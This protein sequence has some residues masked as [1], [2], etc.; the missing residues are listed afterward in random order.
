MYFKSRAH[1]GLLLANLLYDSYRYENCAVLAVNDGGVSVGEQIATQ[2]HCPLM[3]LL[4]E[5]IEV[6]GESVSFGSVSQTGN[7]TY[8]S[9][10]SSGEIDG[11][12]SEFHG[13]LAEQKREKF[14]KINRLLGDG[15]VLDRDMLRDRVVIL[16]TDGA[17]KG[18]VFDAA[19]DFLK[20]IR[21]LKMI[22]VAPVASIPAVDKLH[23]QSDELHILDVKENYMG[24]DHYYDDNAVPSRQEIIAKINSTIL[25]W[26]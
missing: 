4:V 21:I 24:T 6:P 15:G 3:L 9:T 5:D 14:Q 25:N 1:A 16:V 26:R 11:Y 7:F 18:S 12:T 19:M 22:A 13:Y 17:S 10:L 20:P 8:N 2:L 23:V